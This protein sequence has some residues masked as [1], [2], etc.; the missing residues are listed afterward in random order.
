MPILLA[1]NICRA[2]II[3]GKKKYSFRHDGFNV[4]SYSHNQINFLYCYRVNMWRV[5]STEKNMLFPFAYM[6]MI[7]WR[8]RF[9]FISCSLTCRENVIYSIATSFYNVWLLIY[10]YFENWGK[11]ILWYS[12][13]RGKIKTV[14]I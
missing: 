1:V 3:S 6:Y 4:C 10:A 11:Y 2:I 8:R 12:G 9:F 13:T 7:V 14:F 5:W